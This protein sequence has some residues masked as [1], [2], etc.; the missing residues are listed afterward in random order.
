VKQTDTEIST[1]LKY[2]LENV[3]YHDHR[4]GTGRPFAQ[5]KYTTLHQIFIPTQVKDVEKTS[6]HQ[7][8]VH[9]KDWYLETTCIVFVAKFRQI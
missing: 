7:R 4:S 6:E 1:V 9:K 5:V 3:P 8:L 2:R